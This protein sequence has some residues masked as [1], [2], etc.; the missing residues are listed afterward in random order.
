MLLR[1]ICY[2]YWSA[3]GVIS[4][5]LCRLLFLF[6]VL[7]FPPGSYHVVLVPTFSGIRPPLALALGSSDWLGHRTACT[8]NGSRYSSLTQEY[9]DVESSGSGR[10]AIIFL[11][12]LG[13]DKFSHLYCLFNILK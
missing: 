5:V 10:E 8:L 2:R 11:V 9:L 1:Y 6:C 12:S 7:P 4:F 13:K 3:K